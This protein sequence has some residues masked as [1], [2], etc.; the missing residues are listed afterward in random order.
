MSPP[1]A[2]TDRFFGTQCER[3]DLNPHALRHRILSPARLPVP[4]LS[5]DRSE[6]NPST[7]V[8]RVPSRRPASRPGFPSSRWFRLAVSLRWVG[9]FC[10]CTPVRSRWSPARSGRWLIVVGP[11]HNR[12]HEA[13]RVDGS[14]RRTASPVTISKIEVLL[15]VVLEHRM[16]PAAQMIAD[17]PGLQRLIHGW[18]LP[19]R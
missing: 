6:C 1:F 9:S 5:Q 8:F 14:P 3:G 15:P 4:P 11:E 7:A 12:H 13:E 16:R 17:R 18:F 19:S 2:S 10:V